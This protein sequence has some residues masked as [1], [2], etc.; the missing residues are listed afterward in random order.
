LK[1]THRNFALLAVAVCLLVPATR[2][3]AQEPGSNAYPATSQRPSEADRKAETLQKQQE[4]KDEKD[5]YRISSITVATA[6]LLHITPRAAAGGYDL[7]NFA[8][9]FGAIGWFLARKMPGF[10]RGRAESIQ[11]QLVE[12]R[13]ATAEANARLLAIEEKLGK[14]GDD[15]IA[16]QQSAE[17]QAAHEEESFREMIE[18]EKDRIVS[19]AEQEIANAGEAARRGLKLYAAELAIATAEQRVKITPEL[20]QQMLDEFLASLGTNTSGGKK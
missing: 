8:V 9:L 20:D 1:I 17:R 15:I 10:F 3:H 5:E 12:A 13:T 11:K 6:K 16:M 2:A 19:G 18:S 7:L 14:L 4:D